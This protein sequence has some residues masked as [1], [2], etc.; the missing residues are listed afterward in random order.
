MRQT[1]S[2]LI[3]LSI[4]YCSIL[5]L[6]TLLHTFPLQAQRSPK[7]RVLAFYTAKED[8]AHISFV[9][10]ALPWFDSVGRAEGFRFEAT[11][12]WTRL[13]D[14]TKDSFQVLIFLDS[15]PEEASQR[16]GFQRY[17]QSGGGWMG[18]HFAGFAL[19]LSA[20]NQ[21]W[22]WYH[23]HFLGCGQYKSNTW[24]PTG[25]VLKNEQPRHPVMKGLPT[26]VHAAPNEW[27]RWEFDLRKNKSIK[28]LLSIDPS[29]F[30]LGTGPK[31]EEIWHSGDYPV[32]W[33]N[34]NYHML[35]FNMGHNDMDYE[36]G[37]NRSLS[38]TFSSAEQN[39]VIVQGLLWLSK[40]QR[41]HKLNLK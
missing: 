10:E 41:N 30:P 11:S 23:E 33:T 1:R 39:R 12:D 9:K 27:Y 18:F 32:V 26:T 3:N 37:T 35:Y 6:I 8:A 13:S 21:D 22:G 38:S 40:P 2:Y 15:R 24:R 4:R 17:M 7:F 14:I 19:T 28:V 20:F 36:G 16:Q 29:S 31:P 5:L 34:L 25:A